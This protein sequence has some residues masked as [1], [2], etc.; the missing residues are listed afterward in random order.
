MVTLGFAKVT[1]T[2]WPEVL[3]A[4][5]DGVG[6]VSQGWLAFGGVF[7]G[8]QVHLGFEVGGVCREPGLDGQAHGSLFGGGHGIFGGCQTFGVSG[9]DLYEVDVFVACGY[10][11]EFVAA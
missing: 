2:G 8:Y 5:D 11:I 3:P 10:D 4:A 1:I 6:D 7:D 9:F